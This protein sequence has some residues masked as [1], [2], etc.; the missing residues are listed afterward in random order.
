[1]ITLCRCLCLRFR[2][3]HI[4]VTRCLLNRFEHRLRWQAAGILSFLLRHALSGTGH[5]LRPCGAT[6][7]RSVGTKVA[8]EGAVR[9]FDL[10]GR[11]VSS[12]TKGLLIRKQGNEVK[13]VI[14][15]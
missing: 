5:R 13:K 6:G 4:R 8:G 7:I 12:D 3:F 15:K 10:Q 9:Y 11:E 2:D 14:V 1:M